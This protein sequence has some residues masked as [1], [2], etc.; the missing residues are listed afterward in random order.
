V[1]KY[2]LVRDEAPPC[3][4]QEGGG[5]VKAD[6][7]GM[8]DAG[9]VAGDGEGSE[10]SECANCGCAR[11]ERFC[12]SCGQESVSPVQPLREVVHDTAGE[13]LKWDSKLLVT[14][15]P[16]L[17]RPGFLTAEYLAGRRA[18][19]ISPMR[20]YLWVSAFYFFFFALQPKTEMERAFVPP[21]SRPAT[22]AASPA[23]PTAPVRAVKTAVRGE[24]RSREERRERIERRLA[25]AGKWY[26]DNMSSV[27]VFLVPVYA[28]ALAL[29]QWR[30]RRLYVEHLVYTLHTQAFTFLVSLPFLGA[31]S[32]RVSL[33]AS[34]VAMPIYHYAALRR[35]YGQR[36]WVCAVKSALIIAGQ[37]A[38]SMLI[39]AL[40]ALL[41]IL[42]PG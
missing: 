21:S 39:G 40:T 34:L 15:R 5:G 14:L 23:P 16:L 8:A 35:L 19:Y 41:F 3:A 36:P 4:C 22:A 38:I 13:F 37:F 7:I 31:G 11:V 1:R 17:F 2:D 28:L 6:E 33:F 18:P 32:M 9:V 26:A 20:L 30:L 27:T 10:R 25:A 29:V 12:P 42:W 24:P